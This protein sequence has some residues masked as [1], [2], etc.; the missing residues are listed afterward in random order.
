[1]EEVITKLEELADSAYGDFQAK[2]VPGIRR[3]D[4]I[5]VRVPVL[6]AYA[7]EFVNTAPHEE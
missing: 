6:R 4:I 2:L 7:K 5:G 3:E 1:M